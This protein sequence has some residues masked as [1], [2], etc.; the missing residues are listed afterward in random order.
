MTF[1]VSVFD[2]LNIR[3]LVDRVKKYVLA[4]GVQEE[5]DQVIGGRQPVT[6]DRKNLQML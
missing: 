4:E 5:I 1:S 3:F 2:L 6:E